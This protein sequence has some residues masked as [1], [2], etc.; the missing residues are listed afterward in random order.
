MTTMTTIRPARAADANA[1]AAMARAWTA[2]EGKS[3]TQFTAAAIVA[4]SAGDRAWFRTVVADSGQDLVGYATY[5]FSYETEYA[6]PGY[7]IGDLYVAPAARR[8]GIGRALVA[9][10]AAAARAEGAV[11]LWWASSPDN[12]AAH[13]FYAALGA[14]FEPVVAH[15]LT[16]DAFAG[17]ADAGERSGRDGPAGSRHDGVKRETER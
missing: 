6:A 5:S 12:V 9:T 11:Y 7:Y 16:F 10:V 14:T 13:A 2:S 15:A 1:I 4:H 17:L 3:T 8:Q